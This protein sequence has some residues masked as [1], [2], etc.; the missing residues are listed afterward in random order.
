M[1][2]LQRSGVIV[3]GKGAKGNDPK[4][5]PAAR[6]LIHF[7]QPGGMAEKTCRLFKVE[8]S[9]SAVRKALNLEPQTA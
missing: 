2:R 9:F 7:F 8:T 1:R 3:N 6:E 5:S 4:N